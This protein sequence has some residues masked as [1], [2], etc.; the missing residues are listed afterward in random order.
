MPSANY[1]FVY[2]TL[3]REH[4]P[5]EVSRAVRRLKPIGAAKMGGK[6]YDFGEYPGAIPAP[7][8]V[9]R[10]SG[11][12]FEVPDPELLKEFDEYEGYDPARPNRSLFVRKKRFVTLADGRR[13]LSWVYIFNGLPTGGRLLDDGNYSRYR[14]RNGRTTTVARRE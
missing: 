8:R 14:S 10:I 13:L 2:G 6:L 7:N 11:R 9:G 3:L 1:L 4:A 5:R 12:L